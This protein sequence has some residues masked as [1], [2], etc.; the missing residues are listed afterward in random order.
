MA[1]SLWTLLRVLRERRAQEQTC[2]WT[3][4]RLEEHQRQSVA[5]LRQFALAHSPFY[6]DFHRIVERRKPL[7]GA[8][9]RQIAAI[10]RAANP[11]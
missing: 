7:R 2:R 10:L 8:T 1:R 5:E 3:R 6:R 11:S 4:A 9:R